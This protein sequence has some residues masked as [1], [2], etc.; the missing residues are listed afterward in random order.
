MY[1]ESVSSAALHTLF[2]LAP[3]FV[4]LY[5]QRSGNHTSLPAR[6]FKDLSYRCITFLSCQEESSSVQSLEGVA[7]SHCRNGL[8]RVYSIEMSEH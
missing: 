1:L 6:Q 5:R 8:G 4:V 2:L 7:S 3:F